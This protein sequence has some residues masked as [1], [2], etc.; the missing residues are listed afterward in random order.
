[1]TTPIQVYD[2]TGAVRIEGSIN[3]SPIYCVTYYFDFSTSGATTGVTLYTP[4]V[5]DVIYDIAIS[6]G[7]AFDGTTPL[8]DVGTFN[9]GNVGLFGELTTGAVDLTAANTAVTGNAG[10]AH[11]GTNSLK[12]GAYAST[13]KIGLLK[14]TAANPLLLVFSQNGQKGGTATGSTVGSGHVTI[15]TGSLTTP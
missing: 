12:I 15:L 10:I 7:T 6:V 4:S 2:V 11:F 1:M 3:P 8:A 13:A 14:V 5:G 9:G